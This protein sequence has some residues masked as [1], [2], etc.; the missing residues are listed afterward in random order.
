MNRKLFACVL[1]RYCREWFV[2]VCFAV[3]VFVVLGRVWQGSDD[4]REEV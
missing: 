4:G 2:C 1:R 3:V